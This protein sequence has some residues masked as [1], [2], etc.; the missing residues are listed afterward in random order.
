M[1]SDPDELF[2]LLISHFQ[3]GNRFYFS[4]ILLLN[5]GKIVESV[6]KLLVD[7]MVDA[8]ENI[9]S[10]FDAQQVLYGTVTLIY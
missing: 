9:D 1:N 4:P 7:C 5:T 8:K 10:N 2:L 6:V 3:V